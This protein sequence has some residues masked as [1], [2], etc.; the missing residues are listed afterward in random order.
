V[1]AS[2][3]AHPVVWSEVFARCDDPQTEVRWSGLEAV[4]PTGEVLVAASV[5]LTYQSHADGGCANTETRTDG[6]G[7][8]QLT[9]LPGPRAEAPATLSLTP[10]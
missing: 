9:G 10:G 1:P 7:F 4:R 3:L 8:V 2:G 6:D 5:R